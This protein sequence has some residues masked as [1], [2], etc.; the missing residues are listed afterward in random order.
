MAAL[1]LVAVRAFLELWEFER[2]VRAAI[3]L[4]SVG[5]SALGH[6]HGA[7]LILSAARA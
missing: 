5:D 1:G 4:S 6:A 2:E 3:S 7:I